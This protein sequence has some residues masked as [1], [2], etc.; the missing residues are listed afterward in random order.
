MSLRGRDE[1]IEKL[2]K[3]HSGKELKRNRSE[4]RRCSMKKGDYFH[5]SK[6]HGWEY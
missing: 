1:Q 6:Y 2:N 5:D 3:R 4:L